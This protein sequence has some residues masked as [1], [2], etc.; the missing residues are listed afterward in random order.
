MTSHFR[1]VIAVLSFAWGTLEAISALRAAD[2]P[3]AA[4]DVVPLERRP[5]DI[6]LLV[7]Y[8]SQSFDGP[9]QEANLREIRQTGLRCL[10]DLWSL[11]VSSISWL[12]P[13]SENGIKRLSRTVV[14]Q[15]YP[16]ETP[17]IWFVAAVET[18]PVG[19]RVTVRSW[20]PEVQSETD[21]ESIDLIDSRDLA[22][23]LIRLC[24]SL[25]RPM[26]IVEQ[27]EDRSVRIRLRAGELSTPDPSFIQ[28]AE[29]DVLVPML[30]Y[31]N[32]DKIIEKRQTI[33]WTYVTVDRVE[34]STVQGTVQSGLRLSMGGKKRG[35]I[36]TLVVAVRPQH[37][38]TRISLLTQTRPP[39]PLV[40]HRLEVRTRSVIPRP[41]EE[42]PEIDPAATMLSD[43]MTDR[44]GM[45]VV[46]RDSENPL[47]WL[48][49]FSG[50]HLL[51]KVPCVPGLV[52]DLR[53]EVPDDAT[54]LAA[55]A[56]LQ[57]LQGEVI[58]AVALR[59]TA[60]ATIRAAAKKDDW[61][62]VNHKLELL[63]EQKS[64]DTLLDRL[65]AVRVAGTAAAKANKD[66]TAE[67]RIRRMCDESAALINA[68]L[69]NDK[70]RL[71]TE[72][73]EALQNATVETQ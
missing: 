5:Y 26:G 2:P 33:P 43:E 21:P 22:V 29:D 4:V 40:A 14:E 27:V 36:D 51:A 67:A 24:Y 53:L 63:K 6:R 71:L 16:D 23:S 12:G 72:E 55:E 47:V 18:R 38:A 66:K 19:L 37:D 58:D 42:H 52:V 70:V 59:N 25:F 17:D 50:Q 20:Q 56:D 30:A 3:L 45:A 1:V 73:M 34:G 28:L 8:D 10:G 54:R 41:T 31:R 48:F 7:A 61:K 68:H 35:R 62:T 69:A 60:I 32:K 13:V 44:R 57:M 65:T 11:K 49:A 9:T 64:V 15:H 39:V 46:T